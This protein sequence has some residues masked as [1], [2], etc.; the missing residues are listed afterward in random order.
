MWEE[1]WESGGGG[2]ERGGGVG[3]DDEEG[4]SEVGVMKEWMRVEGEGGREE[5]EGG[6]GGAVKW[7]AREVV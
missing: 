3:K 1:F 4:D 7:S 2:E 6:G 5:G